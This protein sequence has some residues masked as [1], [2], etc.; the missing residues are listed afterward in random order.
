MILTGLNRYREFGL[1]ILRV[2]I[3]VLMILHGWPKL[4]G[5]AAVWTKVGEAMQFLGVGIFP[6]F[7][8]F[9]AALSEAVGG[10]LLVLGFYFRPATALMFFTMLVATIMMYRTGGG[11]FMKWSEP[12]E[13]AVVFLG[14]FFI[15]AGKFSL[16][17]A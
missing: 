8:G 9:M 11:D 3:G 6:V 7:W 15:G 10:A 4:V 5:G 14:L 13:M 2:G 1:L 17:R 16:D 12:A